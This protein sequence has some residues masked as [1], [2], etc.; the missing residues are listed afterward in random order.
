[1]HITRTVATF[2]QDQLLRQHKIVVIYGARQ[3]GKT[4]MVKRIVKTSG[5]KALSINAEIQ[6][7]T[8]I[9]SSRSVDKLK[10]FTDG[11]ELLFIDE[12][13]RIPDIGLTLKLIHDHMP[14]LK[15]IVTGSSSL[16][17]ANRIEEPLTGRIW[18]YKLY[19]ISFEEEQL[20][21]ELNNF[22]M[23]QRLYDRM[24][25]GQYPELYAIGNINAK[26]KYLKEISTSYLYKDILIL[27][28][29]KYADKL[30][31]LLRLLAYQV[32]N[33]V[34]VQELARTLGINRDTVINY[35]DLLEKSFVIVRLKGFS[36][37]LR[38]EITKMDKI[39]FVDLGIRNALIDNFSEVNLRNDKGA[40]WENYL[41][42]ERMKRNEYKEISPN[43]YFWRLYSGAEID[44]IEER[45][46]ILAG[47]EIKWNPKKRGR[48]TKWKDTYDNA[49]LDVVNP[50]N[51]AEFL[52]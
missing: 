3:V 27:S 45:D 39:Y 17:L 43:N 24:L 21:L 16:D 28:D 1:M 46:G 48:S 37:N 8:D 18:T 33:L 49:T 52:K 36:G 47:Y 50:D 7:Y 22:E 6:D 25:Y 30:R 19:P 13:Q 20:S 26:R 2:I 51:Y 44:Y 5:L 10:S 31:Q 11:Y 9:L 12:A 40:M 32:G 14:G 29:I 35:I 42:I 23:R 4:T 38:N 15:V 41:I 34:S